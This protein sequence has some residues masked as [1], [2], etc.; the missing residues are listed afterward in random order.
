MTRF[1]NDQG[2]PQFENPGA[3]NYVTVH[4]SNNAVL[5]VRFAPKLNTRPYD[6]TILIRVVKG[7][8]RVGETITVVFGELSG[9]SPGFRMQTFID[10]FTEFRVLADPIA[11]YQYV[12]VPDR[13]TSHVWGRPRPGTPSCRRAG[14]GQALC[15]RDQS[16]RSL[17]NPS[18]CNDR[19]V[20]LR[21]NRPVMGLPGSIT[22]GMGDP[23][24]RI[25]G[26]KVDEPGTV[27]VSVLDDAGAT[28]ATS[29]P[30]VIA[31]RT[32]FMPY[33]ADLHAQSAQR[34]SARARP[35]TTSS[36]RATSLSSMP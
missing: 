27:E 25:D 13:P 18:D 31:S 35:G 24:V 23:A 4:A 26:L 14:S 20:Q 34:R 12:L 32:E 17:G 6:K 5:D 16:G 33:W 30:L 21:A 8:L 22:F 29:N 7:Y 1:A 10:P 2:Q 19:T 11:V 36:S 15:P 28:L 9:G 3:P